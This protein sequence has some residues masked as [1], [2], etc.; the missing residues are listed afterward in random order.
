MQT[1]FLHKKNTPTGLSC[2][3]S[4]LQDHSGLAH[5]KGLHSNTQPTGQLEERPCPSF[6]ITSCIPTT[7]TTSLAMT[8]RGT[9]LTQGQ[10][11]FET[12]LTVHPRVIWQRSHTGIYGGIHWRQN[13]HRN[14]L[15]LTEICIPLRR[16][17]WRHEITLVSLKSPKIP[18]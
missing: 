16:I 4:Y 11:P 10:P 12:S 8:R 15:F 1:F 6:N 14:H 5:R 17:N 9:L 7:K 13:A 3:T 2:K 18:L